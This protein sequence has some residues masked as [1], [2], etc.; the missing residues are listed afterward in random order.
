MPGDG[1]CVW[2]MGSSKNETS[3][4]PVPRQFRFWADTQS[5]KEGK[6]KLLVQQCAMFIYSP[7]Q[8]SKGGKKQKSF[9]RLIDK[10]QFAYAVGV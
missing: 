1:V 5:R 10:L 3:G 4:V 9:R 6:Q 8:W 7:S 2:G